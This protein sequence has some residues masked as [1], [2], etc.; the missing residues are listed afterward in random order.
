MLFLE[1]SIYDDQASILKII[2][3]IGLKKSQILCR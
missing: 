1:E 3:F 2:K